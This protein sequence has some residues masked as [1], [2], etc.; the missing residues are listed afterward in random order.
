MAIS[1]KQIERLRQ[2]FGPR[3]HSI[4][5]EL[6][7]IGKDIEAK[8][9][10]DAY[11]FL[12]ELF[13]HPVNEITTKEEVDRIAIVGGE[14]YV[15]GKL[16]GFLGDKQPD[17][18]LVNRAWDCIHNI[19]EVLKK[20]VHEPLTSRALNRAAEYLKSFAG[21]EPQTASRAVDKAFRE[22]RID[23]GYNTPALVNSLI[24]KLESLGWEITEKQL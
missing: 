8:G 23:D 21:P 24:K 2:E 17:E 13:I 19:E 16:A 9:I 20:K 6:S 4:M 1:A 5:A 3:A 7:L 15:N 18:K 22:L 14:L 10:Y 11:N 12:H